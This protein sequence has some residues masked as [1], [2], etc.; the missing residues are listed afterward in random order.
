MSNLVKIRKLETELFHAEGR[1]DGRTDRQADRQ[2]D[3]QKDMAKI[4]LAFRSY[5][6]E[7]YGTN[8]IIT[9]KS[10]I[11]SAGYVLCCSDKGLNDQR[12]KHLA[13]TS[14]DG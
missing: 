13:V 11:S 2:S 4:I 10:T 14:L 8:G 7:Q 6:I 9:C 1:T 12:L 5:E 3:R